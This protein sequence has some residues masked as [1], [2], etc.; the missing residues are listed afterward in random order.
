V[1][2]A[3]AGVAGKMS[4]PPPKPG[5]VI[6]AGGHTLAKPVGVQPGLAMAGGTPVAPV[7]PVAP[8]SAVVSQVPTLPMESHAAFRYMAIVHIPNSYINQQADTFII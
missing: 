4:T 5:T 6:T 8:R 7:I 2:P 1:A 3:G